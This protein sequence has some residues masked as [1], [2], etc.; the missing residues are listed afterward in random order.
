MACGAWRAWL[1]RDRP[2]SDATKSMIETDAGVKRLTRLRARGRAT[3][4]FAPRWAL[5]KGFIRSRSTSAAKRF[6]PSFFASATRSASS[7][8]RSAEERLLRLGPALTRHPYFPEGTN[9]ELADGRSDR[10]ACAF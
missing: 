7:S 10:I 5:R 6:A 3:V 4:R 9:V 1:I 8:A 2:G